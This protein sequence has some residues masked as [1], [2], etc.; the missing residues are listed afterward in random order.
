MATSK[1]AIANRALQKLG[2]SRISSLT[3]DHPNARSMNAAYDLTRDAEQRRYNWAFCISRASIAKDGSASLFGALNR[4]GLPND[5]LK[6]IRDSNDDVPTYVD[7]KIEGIFILTDDASPL[8]IRYIARIDDPNFYDALFIEA[9]ACKLA[10]ECAE[11][12]TQSTKKKE[13]IKADYAF[14]ISEAKKQGAIEK[15]AQEFP[16]DEWL[17]ARR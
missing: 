4:Y 12:I 14:A 5:F 10:L 8:Q 16:E 7:W 6:L 17:A 11:E 13:S 1:V 9:L 2:A 15:E 3:Q